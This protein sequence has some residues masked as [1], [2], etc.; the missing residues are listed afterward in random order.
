MQVQN[1]RAIADDQSIELAMRDH[2]AGA[3]IEAD[4]WGGH[5]HESL[6]EL[7]RKYNP[8]PNFI[9]LASIIF[10]HL[11]CERKTLQGSPKGRPPPTI[12]WGS[13]SN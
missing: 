2:L 3:T 7:L 12:R 8:N 10:G 13:I 11:Y 5:D 4:R 1:D 6:K 9:E